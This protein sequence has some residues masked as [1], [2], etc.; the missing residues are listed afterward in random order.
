M[1][2]SVGSAVWI[3]PSNAMDVAVILSL[4]GFPENLSTFYN[5]PIR[6]RALIRRFSVY[7]LL[8]AVCCWR[9]QMH[10]LVIDKC[11]IDEAWGQGGW[12]LAECFLRDFMDREKVQRSKWALLTCSNGQ[13]EGRLLQ[14]SQNKENFNFEIGKYDRILKKILISINQSINNYVNINLYA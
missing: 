10:W 7:Y 12:I 1:C 5:I 13:S 6:T 4:L 3:S 9:V 11:V 14:N 2:G 8:M